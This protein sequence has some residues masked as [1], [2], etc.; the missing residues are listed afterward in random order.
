MTLNR[1]LLDENIHHLKVPELPQK[2]FRNIN[3]DDYKQ[4]IEQLRT[5]GGSFW[6]RI[7]REMQGEVPPPKP[8]RER[9]FSHDLTGHE[10]RGLSDTESDKEDDKDK[11]GGVSSDP[12]P[13]STSLPT[14][15]DAKESALSQKPDQTPLPEKSWLASMILILPP[16]CFFLIFFFS[17]PQSP[18]LFFLK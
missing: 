1:E 11:A 8:R 16:P 3:S 5:E 12:T 2:T 14:H 6:L 17:F 7:Y 4:K 15:E 10:R 13:G 18:F 9:R